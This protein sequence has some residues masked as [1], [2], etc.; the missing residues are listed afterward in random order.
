MTKLTLEEVNE[1]FLAELGRL[2]REEGAVKLLALDRKQLMT[3]IRTSREYGA[4]LPARFIF[5]QSHNLKILIIGHSHIVALESAYRAD[6]TAFDAR[7]LPLRRVAFTPNLEAR[8]DEQVYNDATRTIIKST[9][10]DLIVSCVGLNDHVVFSLINHP[11]PFDFVLPEMP[12][13]EIDAAAEMLPFGVVRAALLRQMR[14]TLR[15]L[16]A[17][18]DLTPKPI[19]HLETP[20]PV[21]TAHVLA[22][23]GM[24]RT[25]VD[26]LGVSS[27]AL[28]L[29]VWRLHSAIIRDL[30]GEIGI[31]YQPVPAEAQDAH[32]LLNEHCRANDPTHGNVHYGKL[33]LRQ[34]QT[35]AAELSHTRRSI[36]A[37]VDTVL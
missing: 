29:K 20:P 3:R 37:K 27:F 19:I 24:L 33:V 8:E 34:L 30:C 1:I 11:I 23:P 14:R 9:R 15:G 4:R 5:A 6:P 10:A 36:D 16:R 35:V 26:Q 31:R 32:G 21:P 18:R 2:P 25:K 7:F 28:R 17:L 13:L 12:D 22:W